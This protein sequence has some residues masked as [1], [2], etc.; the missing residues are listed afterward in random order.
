MSKLLRCQVKHQIVF[1]GEVVSTLTCYETASKTV[2]GKRICDTHFKKLK[3][4]RN[5]K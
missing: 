2:N 1:M 3:N 4:P 5:S